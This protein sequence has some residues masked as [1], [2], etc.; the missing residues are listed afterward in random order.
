MG[1]RRQ[2]GEA[3]RTSTNKSRVGG[4]LRQADLGH[5]RLVRTPVPV[6]PQGA[7]SGGVDRRLLGSRR[8]CPWL[9][10][11]RLSDPARPCQEK[12]AFAPRGIEDEIASAAESRA[13]GA[14]ETEEDGSHPV[15]MLQVGR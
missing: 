5:R 12:Y 3:S 1:V 8:S 14:E 15:M 7:R 11:G 9:A 2:S 13:K 6:R 10:G 4:E